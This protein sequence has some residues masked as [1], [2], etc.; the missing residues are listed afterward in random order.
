MKR[1]K[2]SLAHLFGLESDDALTDLPG[3]DAA[4]AVEVPAEQ[5]EEPVAET[6]GVG[7]DAIPEE[8]VNEAPVTDGDNDA[9]DD[10]SSVDTSTVPAEGEKPVVTAESWFMS[11]ESDVEDV[12]EVIEQQEAEAPA[13]DDASAIVGDP[14]E[15]PVEGDIDA[16]SDPDTDEGVDVVL[17][18]EDDADKA[19]ESILPGDDG[20]T[21]NVVGDVAGDVDPIEAV[22][23]MPTDVDH[24]TDT[25]DVDGEEKIVATA[26]RWFV[27][28]EGDMDSLAVGGTD[29]NGDPSGQEPANEQP[30]ST[31]GTDDPAS[32]SESLF[33]IF[34]KFEKLY[35]NTS[36]SAKSTE[37]NSTDF[38][39]SI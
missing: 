34:D 20:A 4:A 13:A 6:D 27:S 12:G 10:P 29:I 14:A 9:D 30:E 8:P 21:P 28:L 19:L 32:A 36:P 23:D 18:S 25:V 38:F 7:V 31:F 22:E 33:S 1:T 5:Y 24:V 2:H 26:E 11:L 39:L 3:T 35:G 15:A 17:P 16:V 37:S